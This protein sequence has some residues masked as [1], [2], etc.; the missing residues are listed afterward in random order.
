[1][2]GYAATG[3]QNAAAIARIEKN[4]LLTALF[5]INAGKWKQNTLTA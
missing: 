3:R 4:T 1:M 2:T 5:I